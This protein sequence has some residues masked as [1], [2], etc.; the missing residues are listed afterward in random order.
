MMDRRPRTAGWIL[1]LLVIKPHLAIAIPIAL[2]MSCRWRALAHAAISATVLCLASGLVLGWDTWA[3]FL[4]DG[5]HAASSVLGFLEPMNFQSV[6]GW[7]TMMGASHDMALVWQGVSAAIAIGTMVWLQWRGIAPAIE[8][9]LI[10]TTSLF[11]SPYAMY[12]DQ[13][14]LIFPCMW[15]A[16]EWVAAKRVPTSGAAVVLLIFI[17]PVVAFLAGVLSLILVARL[18]LMIYLVARESRVPWHFVLDRQA[19]ASRL[20]A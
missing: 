20:P 3:A 15:L 11:V 6:F 8:R 10:V 12:Y 4:I 14:V 16:G 17:L 5:R 7:A 2:I 13:I 19:D 1:G 18:A 9:S